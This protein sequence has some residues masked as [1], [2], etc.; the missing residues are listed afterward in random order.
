MYQKKK[1]INRKGRKVPIA[2][3]ITQRAQSVI[4]QIINFASF[5][6]IFPPELYLNDEALT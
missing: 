2:I 4:C 5:A 3:G 6:L 1:P